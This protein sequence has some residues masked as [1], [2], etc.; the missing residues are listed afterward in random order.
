MTIETG[1]K[2]GPYEVLAFVGAGG[3]GEV[4]RAHDTRLRRDVAIKILR[5]DRH[6]DEAH[7]RRFVQEARTASALNHPNIA[8]IYDISSSDGLDFIVMEYVAGK[9]LSALVRAGLTLGESVRIATR[10]ADALSR[11]HDAGI[12]HRDLKPANVVVAHDGTVKVLDFGLAKLIEP[13]D[14][15]TASV[16][17]AD[18]GHAH[19]VETITDATISVLAERQLSIGGGTPGYMSPEQATGGALDARSD[20]FSFGAMLY[21]MVT[22]R[23]AFQGPSSAETM[24]KVVRD[25]PRAVRELVPDVPAAL[26]RLIDRCLRKSPDRRVQTM[27]DVRVEL[28]DIADERQ[29]ASAPV[30]VPPLGEVSAPARRSWA[31]P[32]AVTVAL[33]VT[34]AAVALTLWGPDRAGLPAPRVVTLTALRGTEATP[35]FSPDGQQIAFAWDGEARADGG[36]RDFDIWL[37]QVGGSE[38]RRLTTDPADDMGPSWSPDGRTIAFHRGRLGAPAAIYVMSPLGGA[39]RKLTDLPAGTSDTTWFRG[40]AVTQLAWS[41]DGRWLA[42]ARARAPHEAAAEAGGIHLIPVAGGPARAITAPAAPGIDRDPA[43]S[44]DGRRLAYASCVSGGFGKCDAFVVD[45]G[46]DLAPIGTPRRLTNHDRTILGLVWA[47]DGRSLIFGGARYDLAHLWRVDVDGARP[48]ERI[49]IA[50]HGLSPAV[51]IGQDRLAFAQSVTDND[52]YAFDADRPNVP[53]LSSSLNDEGPAFSPDGR[54]V[55]FTSGRSGEGAEIWTAN[56]DGSSAAQL[57]RGPG[58]WQGSP[59]WSPDGR[60]IAFDSRGDDGFSDIWLIGVDGGGLRRL[61]MGGRSDFM[62]VW[63]RDGRAIYYG[64]ERPDGGRDV[65]RLPMGGETAGEETV[66]QPVLVA[67]NAFR[68]AESSDGKWLVVAVRDDDTPLLAQPVAAG[69]EGTAARQ[70]VECALA[71][72]VT[73]GPDGIYYVGCPLGA[74]EGPLMRLDPATGVSRRVAMVKTGGGFVPGMTVSPDGRLILFAS[75]VTDGGDLFLIE[76]FR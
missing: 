19:D 20:I 41:P 7:R 4:Y 66:G 49:E 14:D 68:A 28:Q 36:V 1:S 67:A 22:G 25:Q 15:E 54:R 35:A 17:A 57:T 12:V 10:I 31:A 52:V 5:G 2:L 70:V 33:L 40:A 32:I 8:T 63:S 24:M 3:M 61:T 73:R 53:V 43:F 9:P 47:R 58:N 16:R 56:A 75:L 6:P 38:S 74:P 59:N 30:P 27:A 55:A 42:M 39:E 23:R 71:R 34:L 65:W 37:K 60:W 48:A 45:L 21:E 46:A 69:L 44:P 29:S 18:G 76:S 26:E 64:A 11:A 72:S 51:A 50:R 62:P 13:A